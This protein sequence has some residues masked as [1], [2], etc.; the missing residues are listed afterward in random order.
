MSA[1]EEHVRPQCAAQAVRSAM[2]NAIVVASSRSIQDSRGIFRSQDSR[3]KSQMGSCVQHSE[4]RGCVVNARFARTPTHEHTPTPVS[5]N[6]LKRRYS[7]FGPLACRRTC[8][9]STIKRCEKDAV[10]EQ[11]VLPAQ[12]RPTHNTC[13]GGTSLNGHLLLWYIFCC[14]GHRQLIQQE[15]VIG[16]RA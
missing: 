7:P 15:A 11:S 4:R 9:R 3:F 13:N 2:S 14:W 16:P 6:V 8:G 12:V 10:R 5:L 1:S